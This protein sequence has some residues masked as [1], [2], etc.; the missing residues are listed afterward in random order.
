[1]AN[2][3]Y[4]SP[5]KVGPHGRQ[6]A[7]IGGPRGANNPTRELLREACTIFGEEKLVAQIISLGSG[8]SHVSIVERNT[9]TEGVSLPVQDM[10]ADC[11][12]VAKELATRLCDMDGYL[13]LD[14]ERGLES[15]LMNEWD[16][17]GPIDT[18]T[19]AYVQTT[20]ISKAIDA[21]LR[22]LQGSFGTITL[23]E[24]SAYVCSRSQIHLLTRTRSSKS[25]QGP[26]RQ[27]RLVPCV[28]ECER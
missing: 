17:L 22:R 7:F 19:S 14:V 18:H 5:V 4:F 24:I 16:D 15:L 28:Q 10:A 25:C 9:D 21:S 2:P 23:G 12:T 27:G 8:R 6:Q 26:P 20:E 1:M 11:A 3:P 13:R